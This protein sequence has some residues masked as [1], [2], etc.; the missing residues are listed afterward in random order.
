MEKCLLVDAL[1]KVGNQKDAESIAKHMTITQERDNPKESENNVKYR[2]KIFDLILNLNTLND[3]K[4]GL[5][6]L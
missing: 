6:Q 5:A 4:S 3:V 2:N 1:V